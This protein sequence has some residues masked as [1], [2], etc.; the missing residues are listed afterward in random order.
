MGIFLVS[1]AHCGLDTASLVRNAGNDTGEAGLDSSIGDGST[2]SLD[3]FRDGRDSDGA[4]CELHGP[5]ERPSQPE[6]RPMGTEFNM[7]FGAVDIAVPDPV[8]VGFDLD[9]LASM[10]LDGDAAAPPTPCRTRATKAN[11]NTRCDLR[12]TA[13]RCGVDNALGKLSGEIMAFKTI[14]ANTVNAAR[15]GLARTVLLLENFNGTS[16]DDLVRVRLVVSPGLSATEGGATDDGGTLDAAP[17]A[18][19]S[20]VTNDSGLTDGGTGDSTSGIPGSWVLPTQLP[21][22]LDGYVID[23]QLVVKIKPSESVPIVLNG[24]PFNPNDVGIVRGFGGYLVGDM[25]VR[26]GPN[27]ERLTSVPVVARNQLRLENVDLALTLGL[28]T[29]VSM[30]IASSP[31][32][33]GDYSAQF[34]CAAA[35]MAYPPSVN[36]STSENAC[37]GLS[38][39]IRMNMEPMATTTSDASPAVKD[40][41]TLPSQLLRSCP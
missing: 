1:A 15:S 10:C 29:L 18:D 16:R 6:T 40:Y 9:G 13:G 35:D 14:V 24:N 28:D 34:L 19:A 4:S 39:A 38:A 21:E 41:S 7:A 12:A 23:S 37:N 32:G 3:A 30:V 11:I 25:R 8:D 31:S 26:N 27:S 2:T 20:S 36:G 22:P 5:P 17:P 33:V